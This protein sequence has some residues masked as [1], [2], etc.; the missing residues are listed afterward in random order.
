M[1]RP[2]PSATGCDPRQSARRL[3]TMLRKYLPHCAIILSVMYFVFF[4]IEPIY[5]HE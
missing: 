5:F 3:K 4:F 1:T 2:F